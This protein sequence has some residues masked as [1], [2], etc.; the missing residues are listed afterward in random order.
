MDAPTAAQSI[1]INY[2]LPYWAVFQ[3]DVRQT[4]RSWVYRTWVLASLL[5]GVGYMLYRLGAAHE[6]G[7]VQLAST[8]MTHLLRWAVL[9][10]VTLIV[11]LTA[12]SICAERGTLADSVLSRGISRYQY[13]CAKWHARLA[14]I[15]GTFLVLGVAA[16]A[17]SYCFLQE[18]LSL[19]GSA[20]ALLSVACLFV[21]VISCGVACS[22]IA[23][24][25][26]M[27]MTFLWIFLYGI[28]FALSLFPTRFPSP[29]QVLNSLPFIL[30]GEFSLQSFGDLAMWSAAFSSGV[31]LFG[32]LYFSRRDV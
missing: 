30:K 4:T 28:G 12:G 1:K 18:D 10:S 31:A 24:S 19:V 26:M 11:I 29:D 27:G 7:M 17:G 15:I 14:T 20:V 13:F 8:L 32:M 5:V 25:T 16:V 2:W 3:A 22:A 23:D 6:A 9:G 21:V